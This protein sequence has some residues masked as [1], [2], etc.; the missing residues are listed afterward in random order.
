MAL[1]LYTIVLILLFIEE[2]FSG[3]IIPTSVNPSDGGHLSSCELPAFEQG[4]VCSDVVDYSVPTSI[5]RLI[6]VI[7]NSVLQSLDEIFLNEDL[8]ECKDSY[9]KVICRHRFPKCIAKAGSSSKEVIINEH[10]TEELC[11]DIAER[12][13]NVQKR[14]TLDETCSS[15]SELAADFNFRRCSV[16]EENLVTPWMLEYLKAVDLTLSHESAALYSIPGCGKRFAFHKCNFI[17]RCSSEGRVEFINSY[18]SCRS[19]TDW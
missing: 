2:V 19:A 8:E 15:I 1:N 9:R 18:E 10:Y 7:E 16:N 12:V 5:T 13:S 6:K 4:S 3:A 11:G 14:Y 17:G